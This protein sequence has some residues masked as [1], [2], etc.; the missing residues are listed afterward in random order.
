MT[1][2]CP[3]HCHGDERHDCPADCLNHPAFLAHW[4]APDP[5]DGA[6]VANGGWVILRAERNTTRL[7]DDP[8]PPNPNAPRAPRTAA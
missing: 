8:G 4:P 6:V 3:C 5:L 2:D 1:R 7:I